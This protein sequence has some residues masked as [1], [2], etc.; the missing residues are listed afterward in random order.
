[1]WMACRVCRQLFRLERIGSRD[2]DTRLNRVVD[3]C[4]GTAP[5]ESLQLQGS[6]RIEQVE[7]AHC[8]QQFVNR[9][10]AAEAVGVSRRSAV[11][12]T[13]RDVPPRLACQVVLTILEPRGIDRGC[14]KGFKM[15]TSVERQ[16]GKD[17]TIK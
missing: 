1:M 14:R 16:R 8:L 11:P 6:V 13:T 2:R 7:R 4:R 3:R 5:G 9:V 17:E 10:F 15:A 12:L